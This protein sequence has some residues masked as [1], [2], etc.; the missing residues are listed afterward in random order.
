MLCCYG[1]WKKIGDGIKEETMGIT[2]EDTSSEGE[3]CGK[4]VGDQV[5][6]PERWNIESEKWSRCCSQTLH[7]GGRAPGHCD[8]AW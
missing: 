1:N 2:V 8:S 4:G 7:Q 3:M 6:L 5:W